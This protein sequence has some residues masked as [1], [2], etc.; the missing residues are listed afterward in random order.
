MNAV[1]TNYYLKYEEKAISPS[2][3]YIITDKSDGK[4]WE[5]LFSIILIKSF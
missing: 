2:Q 5:N 1:K 4:L 3:I